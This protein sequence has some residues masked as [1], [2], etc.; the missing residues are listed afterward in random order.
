MVS[1]VEVFASESLQHNFSLS[2]GIMDKG[3]LTWFNRLAAGWL[4]DFAHYDGQ[5]GTEFKDHRFAT[6]NGGVHQAS[7]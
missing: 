7:G 3:S 2:L 5:S 1:S 4:A 6:I